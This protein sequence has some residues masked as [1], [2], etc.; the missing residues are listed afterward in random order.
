MI[1]NSIFIGLCLIAISLSINSILSYRVTKKTIEFH[2]MELQLKIPINKEID[3]L[4]QD[5]IEDTFNSYVILN[6]MLLDKQYID[7]RTETKIRS[8]LSVM[9]GDRIS[10]TMYKQL[11]VYYN[12]KVIPTIIANKINELVMG[13][14][15]QTNR[16]PEE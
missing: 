11:A 15:I 14:V 8:E 6:G 12:E 2:T 16:K 1:E 10:P 13:F 3:S 9:V 7:E 5:L 4:L